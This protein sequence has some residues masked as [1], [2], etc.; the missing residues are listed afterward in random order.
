MKLRI[1]RA[2]RAGRP[3][4]RCAA[5]RA[6]NDYFK[7]RLWDQEELLEA[8]FAEYDRLDEDLRA[9]LPLKRVWM[10]AREGPID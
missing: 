5:A 6:R 4:P 8:L 2:P 10:V 3:P 1:P 9:E 7:L